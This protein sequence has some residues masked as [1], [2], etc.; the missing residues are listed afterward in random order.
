MGNEKNNHE[1]D[2]TKMTTKVVSGVSWSFAEKM[3]TEVINFIITI[4]LAR[5][6]LPEAYGTVGLLQILITISL[7]F[8]N[9][10]LGNSLIQKKKPDKL[11]YSTVFV[12]NIAI[13]MC[14]YIILFVASPLVA[15]FY[16][17][18]KLTFMLRIMAFKV[19]ISSIY[20]IQL[21]YVQKNMQFKNLFFS[22]LGGTILSGVIGIGMAYFGFGAWALI[23][24]NLVDQFVD[25]IV[26]FFT[27][28]W[29]PKVKF[30]L[31]K[32]KILNKFAWKV[33]I[34]EL[35]SRVYDQ[36]RLLVIGKAYSSADLAY[37]SKAQKFP[38]QIIETV[39]T[40]VIRVVFPTLSHYQDD[41]ERLVAT[42]S[43]S[44]K[45]TSFCLCPLMVGMAATANQLIPWLL[46]ES[47]NP[48]IPYL[49]L[50]CITYIFQPIHSVN[51]KII[52]AVGRSDISLKIEIIKKVFGLATLVVAVI[53]FDTPFAVAASFSAMSFLALFINAFPCQKLVG[54]G[55]KKEMLDILPSLMLSLLMGAVVMLTPMFGFSYFQTLIIQ[56]I[57]GATIYIFGAWILKFK[58]MKYII[59][60]LKEILHSKVEPE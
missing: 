5:L 18:P 26:L 40:T 2:E 57:V 56:V 23:F 31:E 12:A 32:F 44:I 29:Y 51:I 50:Y 17:I 52:Q 36:S 30:S 19:P 45:F 7:V 41:K 25:S 4:I 3:L 8:V 48:C 42:S 46:T 37:N 39:N 15:K 14:L 35:V 22:S 24:A 28:R 6:L 20:Y 54:Y 27:T 33:T 58:Q 38:M 1:S 53:I 49:R 59:G 16:N 55:L 9:C 34:S 60:Y 11:D 10:G 47:W 43:W 13:G 21:S